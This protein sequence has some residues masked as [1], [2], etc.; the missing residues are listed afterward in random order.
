M[1][2]TIRMPVNLASLV[3]A[4]LLISNLAYADTASE[5]M[6]TINA[7][8]VYV[9][10]HKTGQKDDVS[11]HGTLEF[12]SS[13][14][15]LQKIAGNAKPQKFA[16]IVLTPKHIEV[17][18]LVENQAAV[19][20]YYSEGSMQPEGDAAVGH[21]LTRVTEVYVKEDG[22]WKVRAAHYSPVTGGGGTSQ[23]AVQ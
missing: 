3:G 5:V 12:W 23:T 19:A 20:M 8:N 17:I 13:G 2:T 4:L 6:D 16:Q 15:L 11:K 7:S 10:K 21:Y 14:G 9:Q 1:T 22:K 18:T